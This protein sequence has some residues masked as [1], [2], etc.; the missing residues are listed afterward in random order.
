L[1]VLLDTSI[2]V[3]ILLQEPE[4]LEIG[5]NLAGLQQRVCARQLHL[6]PILINS[7]QR[8]IRLRQ[9]HTDMPWRKLPVV[10]LARHMLICK[11]NGW[12]QRTFS[13]KAVA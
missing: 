9:S 7:L 5:A 13:S 10:I 11:E 4:P 3:R 2:G 6:V 1:I 12:I 8:E